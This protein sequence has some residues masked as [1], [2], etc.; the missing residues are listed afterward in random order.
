MPAPRAV[1]Y[2]VHHKGLKIHVP[3]TKISASGMLKLGIPDT[4]V[5]EVVTQVVETPLPAPYVV[6]DVPQIQPEP[7]PPEPVIEEAAPVVEEL[8]VE[9]TPEATNDEADKKVIKKKFGRK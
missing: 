3:H 1:L 5:D 8:V 2:D 4:Q 7:V 9:S 6:V